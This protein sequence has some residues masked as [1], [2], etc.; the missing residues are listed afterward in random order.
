M[1][2]VSCYRFVVRLVTLLI[3]IALVVS[4]CGRLGFEPSDGV[5]GAPDGEVTSCTPAT[6]V[7]NGIDDDCNTIVDDG[8]PCTAF[9]VTVPVAAALF[10]ALAFVGTG[11]LTLTDDGTT[12]GVQVIASDGT[13]GNRG[14][15]GPRSATGVG[16]QVFA[17]TGAALFVTWMNASQQIML[18]RFDAQAS[19]IGAAIVASPTTHGTSPG[20]VWAGDHGAIVWT[21]DRNGMATLYMRELAADGT[22]LGAERETTLIGRAT[23][24]VVT[25][26][27]YLVS[28]Y[29][30][31]SG[32][33]AIAR[34]GT[35]GALA[36]PL[37]TSPNNTT[38]TLA[39]SP[40]GFAARWRVGFTTAFQ[41]F[42]ADGAL[43]GGAL[44]LPD[45][46]GKSLY[47]AGITGSAGGYLVHALTFATPPDLV[48]VDL[49]VSGTVTAGPTL[50]G[51]YAVNGVADLKNITA[52][53][54]RIIELPTQSPTQ[55]HLI[56]QCP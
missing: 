50:I 45:Y 39:R 10:P 30:A 26:S 18:S 35:A 37:G 15:L 24:V 17:W 21:D 56:Q 43:V 20:V 52:D 1:G 28:L 40:G 41:R 44:T 54:R 9:D 5:V 49:D 34:D 12:Y 11:Y 46:N 51:T 4:G 32:V 42:A 53:H 33:A 8:C 2:D 25:P 13:L 29:G 38:Y 3:T 6:E 22:F 48:S 23:S 36:A 31:A 14:V 16:D 47:I 27:G 7:C 55:L 19:P